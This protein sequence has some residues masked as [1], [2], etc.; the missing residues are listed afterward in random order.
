M[1][2]APYKFT[3]GDGLEYGGSVNG[4][5]ES[6][7]SYGIF[8]AGVVYGYFGVSILGMYTLYIN[9]FDNRRLSPI[10]L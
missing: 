8:M 1:D 5:L 6:D 10:I 2:Q 7:E 4:R 9:V 3:V